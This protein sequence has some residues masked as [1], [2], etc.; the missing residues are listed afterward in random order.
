M[1]GVGA[2][3]EAVVVAVVAATR[4]RALSVDLVKS[5][6]AEEIVGLRAVEARGAGTAAGD[7]AADDVD[8]LVMI[9]GDGSLERILCT[10][11]VEGVDVHEP[12]L[13]TQV[14]ADV[15]G[16]TCFPTGR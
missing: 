11:E 7:A 1:L 14:R 15:L 13:V 10:K 3:F 16:E 6:E 8:L 9:G 12:G 5:R 4:R 2:L